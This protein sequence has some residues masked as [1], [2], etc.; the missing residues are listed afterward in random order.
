MCALVCLGGHQS[1]RQ[2]EGAAGLVRVEEHEARTSNS[3]DD[4]TPSHRRPAG[5]RKLKYKSYAAPAQ[6]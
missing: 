4:P 5:G 2:E 1:D 3:P 6:I